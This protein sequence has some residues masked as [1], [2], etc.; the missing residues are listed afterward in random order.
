MKTKN[1]FLISTILLLSLSFSA[2]A[3]QIGNNTINT[4]YAKDSYLSGGIEISFDSQKLES[5]FTDSLNNNASLKEILNN[6]N[7][8]YNC[9]TKDCSKEYE[10]TNSFNTK[11]FQLNKGEEKVLGFLLTGEIQQ[12]ISSEFRVSSTAGESKQNQLKIDILNDGIYETGNTLI[13]SEISTYE[14]DGCFDENEQFEKASLTSI[15]YCEKMDLN[16]APGF[17]LGAWVEEE[18]EGTANI[19]M[20]LYDSY[21]TFLKEC[22]LP[23]NQ[24]TQQGSEAYCSVDVLVPKKDEYYTCI[25]LGDGTGEYKI[26]AYTSYDETLKCGFQG[27]PVRDL[28]GSYRI[29]SKSKSFAPFSTVKINDTLPTGEQMSLMIEDYIFSEY[30]SSDCTKGCIVPIK[31][32]SFEDQE[33]T[34]DQINLQYDKL[35]ASGIDLEYL[36]ELELEEVTINSEM[37]TLK[38]DNFF[39]M[40][41]TN[42]NISYELDLEGENIYEEEISIESISFR[43]NTETTAKNFPTEFK[44]IT[45]D[46]ESINKFNW[47]FGDNKT[48]ST[49]LNEVTHTYEDIGNYTL[50][51]T[52]ENMDGTEFSQEFTIKVRPVKEL[53]AQKITEYEAKLEKLKT[54]IAK[55]DLENQEII[56]QE[57]NLTDIENKL[58]YLKEK[59][60][61]PQSDANDQEM[62]SV[63]LDISIPDSVYQ[64][65][66][67]QVPFYI[68][69]SQIDLDAIYEQTLTE[70]EEGEEDEAK[71]SI[72]FWAQKN[73][74]IR[75][76]SDSVIAKYGES[77]ETKAKNF[78]ITVETK[79]FIEDEFYLYI[80]DVEGMQIIGVEPE[81]ITGYKVISIN[82][83]ADFSISSE[84][85]DIETLPIF[86]SPKITE[87][88]ITQGF[89]DV[90]EGEEDNR[91]TLFF[92]IILGLILLGVLVYIVLHRWYKVKYEKYLF[93]DR[94]NLY[95]VMIYVNNAKKQGTSNDIIK[96]NLKKSGWSQEQIRYI[97]RKYEGKNTGM[98]SFAGKDLK[99]KKNS[100]ESKPAPTK[101]PVRMTTNFNQRPNRGNLGPGYKI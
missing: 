70:P 96:Q 46:L 5:T 53:I 95:N 20:S 63:I 78:H 87:L 69:K 34:I 91:W 65:S 98:F 93:K 50:T 2:A 74:K 4:K 38:L 26:K 12:I 37:Q 25:S 61:L 13:G 67:S 80:Q 17:L 29:I 6:S 45:S 42:T 92:F 39:Q 9:S 77:T 88:A 72:L 18:Q 66:I 43:L 41:D 7:Y 10:P 60:K 58:E 57:L 59:Q 28:T 16:E 14:N 56:R 84:T 11:T 89:E 33:V 86:I 81:E 36:N 30:G 101:N 1:F 99:K 35:A 31:F 76:S 68:K 64:S 83:S 49:F 32:S 47:D 94:K 48:Q 85:F 21:G 75:I 82:D 44:V 51:L 22:K 54:E 55:L 8:N 71:D 79:E 23:K 3:F 62:I 73:L 100:Q 97:M 90:E 52:A 27:A 19:T 40:P 24:I 15:P